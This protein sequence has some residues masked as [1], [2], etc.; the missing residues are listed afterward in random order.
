MNEIIDLSAPIF[1]VLLCIGCGIGWLLWNKHDWRF[2]YWIIPIF[3]CYV[4]MLIKLT[5][6]PIFIFDK[7]TLD[8]IRE[9]AGK[10]FVF[11]QMIPFASIK[12]YF[13][14]GAMIQ[15][16]GNIVLLSPL[17]LF[18]EIFLCQ[19]L[20]AWKVVLAVSSV[21]F[22]IE[23]AQLTIDLITGY[24]SRVADVD[25]LFLNVTGIVFTII[26][27]RCIGKRQNIRKILQKILYH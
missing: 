16:I 11:Y 20:K 15:L 2:K 19:R 25:D 18:I 5:M 10:Y 17:V 21:S 12:N 27:T 23:M 22:L 9:G 26:L 7:E 3:I 24:P 14:A 4:L 1:C 6:F 8:E 13:R